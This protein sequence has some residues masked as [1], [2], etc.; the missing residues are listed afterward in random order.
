[1]RIETPL[2]ELIDVRTSDGLTLTGAFA[3]P[4]RLGGT[5]RFD[6]VLMMHGAAARF[7]DEFY[8]NF[9]AA[10]VDRGIAT[11][12]ANNRGH[13]I[14]NRG[15]GEGRLA[16]VALEAIDDCALDWRAWLDVLA[17][18]GYARILLF[19][20]SLGAVKS[21]YY[22]ATERDPRVTGLALASP[23]RFN[24]KRML[25]SGRGPEFAASLAEA[26]ALVDT[27][28]SDALIRTTFPLKSFAGASA[29]IAK[30]GSGARFD[31]FA[32]L[33]SVPCPVLGFTGS[34]ELGEQ[35]FCDHPAEYAAARER[36]PDIEFFIVPDGDHHYSRA[37][38][39][40]V[41]R[42]LAWI[43]A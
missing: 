14:L 36:K 32:L 2:V 20:H 5:P 34:E 41:E 35:S 7:Y 22:M 30:Y 10:L 42:F 17:A 39:F 12:R 9:S 37:Q 24:T 31:V 33:G 4:R 13:D 1:M 8:R 19:G 43:D 16:G 15:D 25:A 28:Q 38:A 23:P 6:A 40:V 11:L 26:Q 21:A 3:H 29:Y 27:G 18:R